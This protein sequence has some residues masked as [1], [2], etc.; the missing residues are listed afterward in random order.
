MLEVC[1]EITGL[2][3][4]K[5]VTLFLF[6]PPFFSFV[7]MVT[8]G[9]LSAILPAGVWDFSLNSGGHGNGNE[10]ILNQLQI[11]TLFLSSSLLPSAGSSSS[12]S[13]Q[14][15]TE[16]EPGTVCMRPDQ[17]PSHRLDHT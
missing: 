8:S 17:S 1:I 3:L 14:S 5:L 9:G 11:N 10:A 16:P 15:W 12:S 13:R 2:S 4:L 7:A 6:C